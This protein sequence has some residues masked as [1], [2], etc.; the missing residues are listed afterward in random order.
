MAIGEG[1][2]KHE[3]SM[4]SRPERSEAQSKDPVELPLRFRRRDSSTSLGMTAICS[5]L[6][7]SSFSGGLSK[8]GKINESD[9]TETEEERVGLKIADLD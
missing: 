8:H 4:Q 9:N 3:C 5:F 1:M 7:N 6:R 2:K